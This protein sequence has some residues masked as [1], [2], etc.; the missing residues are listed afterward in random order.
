MLVQSAHELEPG[1]HELE[2][3]LVLCQ[4]PRAE[5]M[6]PAAPRRL[7]AHGCLDEGF[8]D[9]HV[10]EPTGLPSGATVTRGESVRPTGPY[11]KSCDGRSDSP[12]A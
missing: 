12:R 9:P 8:F 5:R 3:E 4:Y 6:S 1:T 2:G 10:F 11:A 7:V